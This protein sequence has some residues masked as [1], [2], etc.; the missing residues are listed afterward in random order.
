VG[1]VQPS[2]VQQGLQCPHCC[3]GD[4]HR[5]FVPGWCVVRIQAE[6]DQPVSSIHFFQDVDPAAVGIGIHGSY[7]LIQIHIVLFGH[8]IDQGFRIL[9]CVSIHRDHS[10]FMHRPVL[11]SHP[12]VSQPLHS[13][14]PF[15]SI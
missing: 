12:S 7:G 2:T 11:A 10:S 6:R 4:E 14:D 13:L 5:L 1:Q 8:R 9:G 15:R 3:I